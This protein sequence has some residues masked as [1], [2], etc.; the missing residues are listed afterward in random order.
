[1]ERALDRQQMINFINAIHRDDDGYITIATRHFGV[2]KQRHYHGVDEILEAVQETYSTKNDIYV[3]INS[4]FLPMRETKALRRINAIYADIDYLPL[5]T[6]DPYEKIY[7]PMQYDLIG[8]GLMPSPSL[9][10]D[11]GHGMHLYWILEDVPGLQGHEFW[12]AVSG[13]LISVL[14]RWMKQFETIAKVDAGVTTDGQRVMRLPGT[15]N[16]MCG[17][18]CRIVLDHSEDIYRLDELRD[19][20]GFGGQIKKKKFFAPEGGNAFY[21]R[22][23]TDLEK[24]RDLRRHA[25]EDDWCRRRTTF[26]FRHFAL[27]AG[28]DKEKALEMTKE[29]NKG[30]STPIPD[31]KLE[32]HTFSAQ[33]AIDQGKAYRYRII[34]LIEELAITSAEMKGMSVLIDD[35]TRQERKRVHRRAVYGGRDATGLTAKQREMDEARARVVELVGQGRTQAEIAKLTGFSLS[36]VKRLRSEIAHT[37][38]VQQPVARKK[39]KISGGSKIRLFYV[40]GLTLVRIRRVN[41]RTERQILV[42]ARVT[43]RY[44]G[45][46]KRLCLALS[47]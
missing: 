4:F 43:K 44:R 25:N 36:K 6:S 12:Q 28:F 33:K 22:L 32:S 20:Y 29:F 5:N 39:L 37:A 16:Q 26:Y 15:F 34:T 41:G 18:M 1:M 19:K 14:K 8:P 35:I 27:L 24:L 47:G 3:S 13:G 10:V 30:F 9:V 42:D 2:W 40:C 46:L 21:A 31:H 7:W 38:S 45:R 11:S 17:R 23:L